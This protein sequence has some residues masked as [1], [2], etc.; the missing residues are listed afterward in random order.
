MRKFVVGDIH[1]GYIALKQCLELANFDYD[2]DRLII[3]GDVCDGWSE[4]P[5]CI[6][7]LLKIKNLVAIL[8]NHDEW[9]RRFLITFKDNLELH[10][11]IMHGG[12]ATKASY[13]REPQLRQ[14]HVDFLYRMVPYYEDEDNRLF[15]HAGP[16]VTYI[17]VPKVHLMSEILPSEVPELYWSR[18]FWEGMWAGRNY[19]A[20]WKEVYIGHTPTINYVNNKDDRFKP[21][22]RKNVCNMDTGSCFDG[23]LSLLNIETKELFQ[24]D[25]CRKLYRNE[26]G[27]N[28]QSLDDEMRSYMI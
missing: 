18:T 20:H 15:V 19:G 24:S 16:V 26:K 23:S 10:S 25:I 7:E 28:K 8:G 5:E 22:W 1:G 9:A 3:L 13:L 4:T 2:I 21:I 11:W 14:K 17:N 12:S 27:R 6:E